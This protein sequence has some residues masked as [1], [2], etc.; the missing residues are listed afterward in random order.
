MSHFRQ[1]VGIVMAICSVIALVPIA[2]GLCVH[3][4]AIWLLIW[5]PFLTLALGLLLAEDA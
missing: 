4:H 3:H 5:L 2:T 1:S